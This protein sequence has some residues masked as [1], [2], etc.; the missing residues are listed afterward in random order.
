M[1]QSDRPFGAS[2]PSGILVIGMGSIL[3]TRPA[4][5]FLATAPDFGLPRP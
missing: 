3:G 5:I 1:L 4:G 2:V